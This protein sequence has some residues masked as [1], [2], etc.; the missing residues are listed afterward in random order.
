[1]PGDDTAA[2][3]RG[4]AASCSR[5][6]PTCRTCPSCPAAAPTPT[7]TGRALAVVAG[8][9]ADLQPAGWRLTDGSAASTTGGRGR[10]SRRT[11]TW[12]RS[13]PRA[14]PARSRSRSP[15]RGRWRPPSSGPAATG[16]SPTTAPA[17]SSRSRSP[18]GCAA[19]SPT[20]GAGSRTPSSWCRSTS[21][22]SPAVLAGRV[23]TASGFHR[24][25]TVHPPDA[26]AALELGVAAV[27]E[28]GAVPVVHC[29]AS[30]VP[31]G[32]LTG[33]G[34][35]GVSVD[36]DVLP[37]AAYD[38][39]AGLLEQGGPVLLGVV[40]STA[41]VVAAVGRRG[42]RAGAA[43]ARDARPRPRGAPVARGH[44]VLRAG[45]GGRTWARRALGLCRTVA[46]NLRP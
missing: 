23:P 15:G 22:R 25:R 38:D 14:T 16:C 30:D 29:C 45:R 35:A 9:G 24:H 46:A 43:A 6:C 40:P 36:L 39:L 19:T 33:A 28:A 18:R 8:L 13:R 27:R 20:S 12:S 1:M 42:D 10:C 37:A 11:S 31:V 17:A 41:P 3:E 21:R 5:S 26:S 2:F 34:A 44:A 7:M 32:L 4:G